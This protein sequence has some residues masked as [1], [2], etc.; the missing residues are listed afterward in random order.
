M[1]KS[2]FSSDFHFWHDRIRLYENR[3]FSNVLEMNETIIRR[4]NERIKHNDVLYFLGDLG[5]YC[6]QAKEFRGEGRHQSS[7]ELF[8][9]ING[10]KIRISGNHDKKQNHNATPMKRIVLNMNNMYIN[11]IHKPEDTVIEDDQY[12]YPLTIHGHCH[13]KFKTK[14]ITNK[15]KKIALCINVS[16]ENNN[17]YPFSFDEIM[18]I[19]HRWLNKLSLQQ[20]RDIQIWNKQSRIR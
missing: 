9:R 4:C 20:K 6:S 16:V 12:Y 3:P 19:Y 18:A 1:N 2:W 11:L 8:E 5:F 13:G 14:E 17:Y 15:N 10:Y 7:L